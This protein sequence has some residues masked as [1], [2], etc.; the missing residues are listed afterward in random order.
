MVN[1]KHRELLNG[2]CEDVRLAWQE[3]RHPNPHGVQ[4]VIARFYLSR[5]SLTQK[6]KVVLVSDACPQFAD[7]H[8][9]ALLGMQNLWKPLDDKNAI[10][11]AAKMYWEGR[12]WGVLIL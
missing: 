8:S 7:R 10:N 3:S 1:T 6:Y 11:S 9:M 4:V 2:R 12:Y 5:S